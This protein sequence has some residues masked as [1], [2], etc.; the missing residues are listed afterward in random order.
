MQV[1]RWAGI[2]TQGL[3]VCKLSGAAA[4][5]GLCAARC[6]WRNGRVSGQLSSKPRDCGKHLR[7]Q[8]RSVAS[9]RGDLKRCYGR[10][11]RCRLRPDRCGIRR[12][13]SGQDAGR[14]ARHA[15]NLTIVALRKRQALPRLRRFSL[16]HPAPLEA[17]PVQEYIG[18]SSTS[19]SSRHAGILP[20]I[21]NRLVQF[22]S[23]QG[24]Y[25][26][27]PQDSG[28][29]LYPLV[30]SPRPSTSQSEPLP[31][32]TRAKIAFN[33]RR[34]ERQRTQLRYRQQLLRRPWRAAADRNCQL[35]CPCLGADHQ[36]GGIPALSPISVCS[37]F[38]STING[39][40]FPALIP[41]RSADMVC[42]GIQ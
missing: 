26:R 16:H 29:F 39:R 28:D 13:A 21:V 34:L 24:R 33:N 32:K 6:I 20:S 18:N 31:P 9:S 14:R 2:W 1:R 25:P 15:Q 7:D 36:G 38:T 35:V 5:N 10:A 37:A 17:Q 40:P 41:A 27:S 8:P 22:A 11:A 12:R 19:G 23:R 42:F 3:S 30:P 4:A